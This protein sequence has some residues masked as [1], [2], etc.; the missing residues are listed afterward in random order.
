MPNQYAY[1]GPAGTFSEAALRTLL[2][3]AP[4]GTMVPCIGVDAVFTAVREG[5]VD[6]GV[7]PLENSVEGGVTATI[8]ELINGAPVM[9]TAEVAVPVEFTLFAREG[10][11]LADIKRVAT[12]PHALAQCRD[13]LAANL[14][15][16]ETYSVSS[17]AAAAQAVAEPGSQYDAAVSARIGGERYGL[18]AVAE[19]VGDHSA[20]ATRFIYVERPGPPPAPTGADRTSFVAFIS[21]DHPGALIE[22]LNQFAMRGVNLTRLESRPTGGGL[23]KYCFCI[24]AEGHVE[25]ARV[26]EALM[27]MRRIGTEVRFLGSYPRADGDTSPTPLRP[28]RRT[29]ND[30][31]HEAERWLTRIRSG[32][33]S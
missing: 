25:E 12:H 10:V 5:R 7:V 24:D 16:A 22:L 29:S 32:D 6:G 14:P 26:G 19:G 3:E 20:A 17:T 33:V 28:P 30:D 21:D 18:H 23:G 27:G 2:P 11:A 1:L 15:D 9:I 8:A 31:F 13:W 4:V